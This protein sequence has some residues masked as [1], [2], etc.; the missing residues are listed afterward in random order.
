MWARYLDGIITTTTLETGLNEEESL[1]TS[2]GER[3]PMIAP[4]ALAGPLNSLATA[5][6]TIAEWTTAAWEAP[7]WRTHPTSRPLETLASLGTGSS[8]TRHKIRTIILK[9]QSNC[10]RD[11]RMTPQKRSNTT[12]KW[13]SSVNSARKTVPP[14]LLLHSSRVKRNSLPLRISSSPK[15][16]IKSHWNRN[17][18]MTM[19]KA[20]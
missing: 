13:E 16:T 9:T 15:K 11:S 10:L 14:L 17:R 8:L 5:T 20:R 7:S 19:M 6:E 1:A 12:S 18:K 4:N 3:S 2:Q